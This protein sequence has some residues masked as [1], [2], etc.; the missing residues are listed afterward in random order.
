[1]KLLIRMTRKDILRDDPLLQA[2]GP[3]LIWVSRIGV[4]VWSLV[5]G[6]AMAVVQAANININ[7]LIN[8]IGVFVGGAVPPLIF[9]LTWRRCN[10]VM[11]TTGERF[12]LISESPA[13]AQDCRLLKMSMLSQ[14]A[15]ILCGV[16]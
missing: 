5:M 12:S 1:M 16:Q 3:R 7:W 9:V 13:R 4:V 8:S 15:C 10:G 14:P 6:I 2:L 11:A